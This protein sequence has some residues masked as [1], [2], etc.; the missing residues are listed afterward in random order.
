MSVEPQ[1]TL[2]YRHYLVALGMDIQLK[3]PFRSRPRQLQEL[4]DT[5]N[6][7]M[8]DKSKQW[9]KKNSD[10]TTVLLF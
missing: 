2:T 1:V 10:N 8:F 5:D 4:R 6:H 7:N 3:K 9:M